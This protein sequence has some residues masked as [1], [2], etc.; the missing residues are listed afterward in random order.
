MDGWMDGWMD[1]LED[2]FI[3]PINAFT[4][5]RQ[6]GVNEDQEHTGANSKEDKVVWGVLMLARIS[7]T[8]LTKNII[9]LLQSSL[10]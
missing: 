6:T 4:S 3:F 10:E 2:I 7:S 5:C 9:K 8:L 1:G